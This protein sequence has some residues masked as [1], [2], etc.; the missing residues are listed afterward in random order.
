M[1]EKLEMIREKVKV[2]ESIYYPYICVN[3]LSWQMI[4]RPRFVPGLSRIEDQLFPATPSSQKLLLYLT[5]VRKS[6]DYKGVQKF[7][8]KNRR[9]ETD[10]EN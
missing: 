9:E 5:S 10:W 1:Y 6:S 4:T 3:G 7:R 2:A 8:W